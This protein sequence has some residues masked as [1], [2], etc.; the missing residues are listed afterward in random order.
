MDKERAIERWERKMPYIEEVNDDNFLDVAFGEDI[1]GPQTKFSPTLDL[2]TF[3]PVFE[4]L[5]EQRQSGYIF[6]EES[7]ESIMDLIQGTLSI[8]NEEEA[9]KLS[10]IYD[11]QAPVERS[12]I[13]YLDHETDM[14]HYAEPVQGEFSSTQLPLDE[15][16]TATRTPMIGIHTH[17]TESLPSHV[18]YSSLIT[19]VP[20]EDRRLMGAEIV[21]CPNVQILVF[22]S[23]HTPRLEIGEAN[24]MID[25]YGEKWDMEKDTEFQEAVKNAN[26]LLSGHNDFFL[27]KYKEGVAIIEEAFSDPQL[28]ED[29]KERLVTEALD[30]IQNE[31]DENYK[32][33]LPL[34]DEA[35]TRLHAYGSH[36]NNLKS[37]NMAR[38]M[39]VKMYFSADK[40]KFHLLPV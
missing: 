31:Q 9:K 6:S 22:P 23:F 38:E 36:F 20:Y 7:R 21:L 34:Y 18:D 29:E 35:T 17:P 12:T 10:E 3:T 11:R 40:R 19:F 14:I 26:D 32:R 28:S 1:I 8:G 33:I 27:E 39:H 5:Y 24:K 4:M 13:L 30:R 37:V 25:E 16:Y 15:A 2:S